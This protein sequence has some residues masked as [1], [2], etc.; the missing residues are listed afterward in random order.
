MGIGAEVVG[1]IGG[2][3]GTVGA[4]ELIPAVTGVVSRG[5]NVVGAT[6]RPVG[7]VGASGLIPAVTGVERQ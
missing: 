4:S 3:V 2:P 7:A 1:A 6:G 5:K